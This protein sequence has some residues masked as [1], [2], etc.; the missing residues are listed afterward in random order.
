MSERLTPERE[1][2]ARRY[3]SA[4]ADDDAVAEGVEHDTSETSDGPRAIYR[5]LWDS[6]NAKRG[7]GWD[8]NPWVWVLSFRKVTP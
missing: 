2:L 7:Y 5:R 1:E 3:A 6:L 8:V 4:W